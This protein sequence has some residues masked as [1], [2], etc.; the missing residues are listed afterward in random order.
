MKILPLRSKHLTAP[1]CRLVSEALDAELHINGLGHE[2][3][4]CIFRAGGAGLDWPAYQRQRLVTVDNP[5]AEKQRSDLEPFDL[6]MPDGRVQLR[7]GNTARVHFESHHRRPRFLIAESLNL[8][9]AQQWARSGILPVHAAAFSGAGSGILV[10]GG[11][12]SGKSTLGV[13]AVNAGMH[14]VSDD[15]VLLGVDNPSENRAVVERLRSF[16][17]LRKGWSTD[18]LTGV[19]PGSSRSRLEFADHP[20]RPKRMMTMPDGDARFPPHCRID[21]IWI[22]KRPRG[23]RSARSRLEPVSAAAAYAALISATLPILFSRYFRHERSQMETRIR[24]ILSRAPAYALRTGTDLIEEPVA[25]FRRL[26]APNPAGP[27][28][29]PIVRS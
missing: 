27:D 5:G 13:A 15:W 24:A 10:F 3:L 28:L 19:H 11:K 9:L 1:A 26:L 21:S 29:D 7:S 17:M 22:L 16:L 20:T 6:E 8:A 4:E 2:A 12:A 25:T 23:A 18:R 14:L